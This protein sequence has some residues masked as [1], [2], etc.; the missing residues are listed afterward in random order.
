MVVGLAHN[1][2][3]SMYKSGFSLYKSL[4]YQIPI[5]L[6]Y[7]ERGTDIERELFICIF[8]HREQVS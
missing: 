6:T 3:F 2:I 4:K 5:T 1:L 8:Q 7:L